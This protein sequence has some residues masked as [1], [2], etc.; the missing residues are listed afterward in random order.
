V[1]FPTA[2]VHVAGVLSI[3]NR[4]CPH[5]PKVNTCARPWCTCQGL[6]LRWGSLTVCVAVRC[7]ARRQAVVNEFQELVS[8]SYSG[9]VT[10]MQCPF[11]RALLSLYEGWFLR[12]LAHDKQQA[13]LLAAATHSAGLAVQMS[14]PRRFLCRACR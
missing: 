5:S 6:G 8:F 12:H 11:A 3:T 4:Y 14:V 7:V 2:T 10:A 9:I 13:T 1:R